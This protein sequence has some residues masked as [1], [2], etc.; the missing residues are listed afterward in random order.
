MPEQREKMN[1]FSALRKRQQADQQDHRK[2]KRSAEAFTMVEL[3]ITMGIYS[4]IIGAMFGL[5]VS[6]NSFFSQINGRLDVGRATRKSM[7]ILIKEL[8][9]SKLSLVSVFDRPID[10]AGVTA[11]H[12]NGRS[13]VFQVPV[14]WDNDDDKFDNQ[15]RIE[16]GADG[17]LDWVLEYC[18]DST[19]NQLLRRVWDNTNTL[20]SGTIVAPNMS[21]FQIRGFRYDLATKKYVLDPAIEI[22]DITLTVR[23]TSIGGRTL[24]APLTYTLNNRVHCRN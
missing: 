18:W 5:I 4:V 7:N 16:W 22:V 12:V 23:K 3:I 11:D 21:S 8:R 20:S 6:Q 1:G 17:N 19:T 14:D 15:G 2:A 24:S 13:I 9:T 10:Q